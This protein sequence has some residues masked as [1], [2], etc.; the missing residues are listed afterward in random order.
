MIAIDLPKAL[1]LT[2]NQRPPHPAVNWQKTAAIRAL[3][4]AAA[5][6]ALATGEEVPLTRALVH[7]A[8]CYPPRAEQGRT[9]S[10]NASLAYKAAA[11]GCVDAGLLP[12]DDDS[13]VLLTSFARGKGT[14]KPGTYRLELTF[15]EQRL[16]F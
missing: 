1:W 5:L 3:A 8:V 15:T 9:D 4:K 13:H 10:P 7:V 2:P 14:G 6:K 12:D 11:D 16:D